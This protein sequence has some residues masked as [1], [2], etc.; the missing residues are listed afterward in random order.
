MNDFFQ[1]NVLLENMENLFIAIISN[2][3]TLALN[4]AAQAT[5]SA[6]LDDTKAEGSTIITAQWVFV[7]F[8]MWLVC[9]ISLQLGKYK[10]K[11]DIEIYDEFQ[12]NGLQNSKGSLLKYSTI[13]RIIKLLETS[14]GLVLAW[15]LRDAMKATILAV[16]GGSGTDDTIN[17]LFTFAIITSLFVSYLNTTNNRYYFF[18]PRDEFVGLQFG[19]ESRK[20]IAKVISSNLQA[21]VGIAWYIFYTFLYI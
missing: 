1:G 3:T 16:Y 8:M 11:L 4:D 19:T 6:I 12:M 2:V 20:I 17:A 13:C 14:M 18:Y 10:D 9:L 5:F 21:V 7:G 15:S